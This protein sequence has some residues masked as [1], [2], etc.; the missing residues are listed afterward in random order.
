MLRNEVNSSTQQELTTR[1]L[2]ENFQLVNH[3]LPKCCS[4]IMRKVLISYRKIALAVDGCPEFYNAYTDEN[5]LKDHDSY[6]DPSRFIKE[7]TF[8]HRLIDKMAAKT[9]IDAAVK[10]L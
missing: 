1:P 8:H 4:S 6:P 9:Q 5:I 10:E 7:H 3:R 2:L